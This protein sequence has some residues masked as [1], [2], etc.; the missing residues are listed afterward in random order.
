M[1]HA[2]M[3]DEMRRDGEG[4]RARQLLRQAFESEREAA[5]MIA[6]DLD[7]EPT[8]SVLHRSA[9]VFA[10]EC[11][12]YRE[13]E[14][15]IC[16]ALSGNPPEVIANELR[17]LLEQVH[18]E[19]HL[20]LQ[21]VVL[22][23]NEMQLSI[24][25]KAVG[26]GFAQGDVFFDRVNHTQSMVLRTGE[27]KL[28][29][30]Y[31]GAGR[32]DNS[33]RHAL[34]PCVST[35]RPGSFTVSLRF[36]RPTMEAPLPGFGFGEEVIDEVLTC[37]ELFT[38]N[39]LSKLQLRIS[40]DAYY[41]NF[42]GLANQ[43]APD[44][45]EVSLVGITAVRRG[46]E[47]RIALVERRELAIL[48]SEISDHNNAEMRSEIVEVRGRLLFAD[49]KRLGR[50]GKKRSVDLELAKIELIDEENGI[51]HPI[52]VPAGMMGDIVKPLWGDTVMVKGMARKRGIE[53]LDIQR[54][55]D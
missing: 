25:G 13:A 23:G 29:R 3:A 49:S 22:D 28:K 32:L 36:G 54:L 20:S 7:V 38:A 18:F 52:I 44:G 24:A 48:P 8:R 19:R 4:D 16:T 41:N 10:M 27:R 55:P 47:R 12:E 2:D 11:A 26:Y 53:L 34:Q 17:N 39:E 46:E 42:V 15:L 43:L 45:D 1:E 40:D 9:A 51:S 31:R 6:G 33:L 37:L 50:K 30:P 35:P 14:K 5:S 21:G